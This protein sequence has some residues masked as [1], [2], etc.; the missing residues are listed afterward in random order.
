MDCLWIF[1]KLGAKVNQC[2]AVFFE[3][4]HCYLANMFYMPVQF[5]IE[6]SKQQGESLA[7]SVTDVC[8]LSR[9]LAPR[10]LSLHQTTLFARWHPLSTSTYLVARIHC[11]DTA[12]HNGF[13][14][15]GFI[16]ALCSPRF[17]LSG[18]ASRGACLRH[19]RYGTLLPGI[20]G[21]ASTLE[22][23]LEHPE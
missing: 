13:A 12:L 10:Q 22:S 3:F 19:S 18:R 16:S 6:K 4:I 15:Y 11:R 8:P 17:A 9:L 7:S 1:Y 2:G 21:P 23:L 14:S 20:Q 5:A